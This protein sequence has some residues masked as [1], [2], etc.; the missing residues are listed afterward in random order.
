MAVRSASGYEAAVTRVKAAEERLTELIGAA[1]NEE[2]V[3]M[4]GVLVQAQALD[5]AA[6]L[7]I[8]DAILNQHRAGVNWG[9]QLAASI[10]RIAQGSA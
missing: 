7:N 1:L 4:A 6:H 10:M 9:Q 2:P 5:A 8:V 3:T